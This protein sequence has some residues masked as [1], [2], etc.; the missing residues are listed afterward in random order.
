MTESPNVILLRV[1]FIIYFLSMHTCLICDTLIKYQ[2][3]I[4]LNIAQR[5]SGPFDFTEYR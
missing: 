3:D 1:A 2:L 5:S 4:S